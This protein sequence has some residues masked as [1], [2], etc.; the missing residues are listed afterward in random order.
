MPVKMY[1][2]LST[3]IDIKWFC[4]HCNETVEKTSKQIDKLK[5]N[6]EVS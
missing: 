3:R 6:V 5:K 2:L 4:P 1:N